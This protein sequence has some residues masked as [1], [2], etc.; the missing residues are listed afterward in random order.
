MPGSNTVLKDQNAQSVVLQ[1]GTLINNVGLSYDHP[2]YLTTLN[3]TFIRQII[4]INCLAT[5]RVGRR[6]GYP[7]WST[8]T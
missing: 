6:A 5:T 1:V 3:D 2:D 7:G 8:S 4:E